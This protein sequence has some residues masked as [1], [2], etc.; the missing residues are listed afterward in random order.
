[1]IL[2][3]NIELTP[4]P[5]NDETKHLLQAEC[6]SRDQKIVRHTPYTKR[7]DRGLVEKRWKK[8]KQIR[9]VVV[10]GSGEHEE[11]EDN[12]EMLARHVKG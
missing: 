4:P 1:M 6:T 3:S 10:L 2:K 12:G 5:I 11:G 9:D 8:W 7:H